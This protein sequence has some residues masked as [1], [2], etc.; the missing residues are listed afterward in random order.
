M[1][2]FLVSRKCLVCYLA[3]ALALLGAYIVYGSERVNGAFCDIWAWLLG[4]EYTG[5]AVLSTSFVMNTWG[6]AVRSTQRRLQMQCRENIEMVLMQY[7]RATI[8]SSGKKRMWDYIWAKRND[9]KA[10]R[11]AMKLISTVSY[12]KGMVPTVQTIS[13]KIVNFV[14]LLFAAIAVFC[15]IFEVNGRFAAFLLLPYPLFW[16]YCR[17]S[18]WWIWVV[19]HWRLYWALKDVPVFNEYKEVLEFEEYMGQMMERMKENLILQG[20][21]VHAESERSN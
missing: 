9:K 10:S 16:M 18:G 4:G 13:T 12:Y 14:M 2:R 1:I 17:V 5:Y 7:T 6:V 11:R 21:A 8:G 20:R 19:L 3:I 15:L